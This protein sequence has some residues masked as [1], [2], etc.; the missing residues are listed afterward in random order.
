MVCADPAEREGFP[1]TPDG[2][3]RQGRASAGADVDR[4]SVG[5]EGYV[6]EAEGGVEKEGRRGHAGEGGSIIMCV[7]FAL[8]QALRGHC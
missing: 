6:G 3:C 1:R 5:V 4:D 8:S 2:S 7:L